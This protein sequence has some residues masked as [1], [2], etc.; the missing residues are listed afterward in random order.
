IA[1]TSRESLGRLNSEIDQM[2]ADAS[3]PTVMGG[4]PARLALPPGPVEREAVPLH[5]ATAVVERPSILQP[6]A[7]PIVR[8]GSFTTSP[9]TL[10]IP[11]ATSGRIADFARM[12]TPAENQAVAFLDRLG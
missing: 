11:G 3:R 4:A 8:D 9:A 1:A 2:A 7:R 5:Q 6:A 10:N 12:Q